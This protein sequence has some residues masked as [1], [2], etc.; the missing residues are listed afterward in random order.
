MRVFD[1]GK[2]AAICC[3][4]STVPFL[5]V[6]AKIAAAAAASKWNQKQRFGEVH[7]W[8]NMRES[9]TR[10]SST[11]NNGE[12]KKKN[13]SATAR[14]PSATEP[15]ELTWA[16][17][18]AGRAAKFVFRCRLSAE[19]LPGFRTWETELNQSPA[20]G[21]RAAKSLSPQFILIQ[22]LC[23]VLYSHVDS[24][25]SSRFESTNECN[26]TEILFSTVT[27]VCF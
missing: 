17:P 23:S 12:T 20:G 7:S 19:G 3:D 21:V 16:E 2:D 6:C 5:P 22:Y 11:L 15:T 9:F 10:T 1:I 14:Q 26:T 4:Y 8:A 27:I 18:T 13:A 25:E 24:F